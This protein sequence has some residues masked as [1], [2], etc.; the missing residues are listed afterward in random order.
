VMIIWWL[1]M[2]WVSAGQPDLHTREGL[3]KMQRIIQDRHADKPEARA[4]LEMIDAR[5][6]ELPRSRRGDE[7]EAPG[8]GPE[9]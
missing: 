7:G 4:V 3:L 9:P 6:E 2:A 8:S 5:L 1:H